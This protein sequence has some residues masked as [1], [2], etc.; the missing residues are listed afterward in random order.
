V[1][2]KLVNQ[3]CTSDFTD[4]AQNV[5]LID[6][7]GTG[8]AHLATDLGVA[9][10]TAKG[11]REGQAD[12]TALALVRMDLFGSLLLTLAGIKTATLFIATGA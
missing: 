10:I 2:K 11:K 7:S 1:E 3:L 5:V 12:R 8:K 6:G 4:T 9:G